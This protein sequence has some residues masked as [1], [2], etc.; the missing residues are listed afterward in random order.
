MRDGDREEIKIYQADHTHPWPARSVLT[1][2][3]GD[4]ARHTLSNGVMWS[5][6]VLTKCYI[7]VIKSFYWIRIPHSK[8][9]AETPVSCKGPKQ[10][11]KYMFLF[12]NLYQLAD[13]LNTKA[14]QREFLLYTLKTKVCLTTVLCKV[15]LCFLLKSPVSLSL[16][17]H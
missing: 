13:L 1:D 6:L 5:L 11:S 4:W 16:P 8:K 2:E 14:A 10:V 12:Q 15:H 17:E 7:E 9:T 3:P